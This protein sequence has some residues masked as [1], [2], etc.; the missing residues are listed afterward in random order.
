MGENK[1]YFWFDASPPQTGT[2]VSSD[3]YK[4]ELRQHFTGWHEAVQRLIDVVDPSTMARIEIHDTEPLLS[5][6]DPSGR[7]VIIGDAAHAT[8]PD[9]GQGG[10]QALED[11][12]VLGQLFKKEG[13]HGEAQVVNE[14]LQTVSEG[15]QK[16]RAER[17]AGLVLRARKRAEVTHALNGMD[18]T[19][20]TLPMSGSVFES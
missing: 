12:F 13:L 10:C 5:L 19:I 7:A 9:L 18:E 8:T 16:S 14:K 1:F 4:D 15:Y 3:T 6:T 20:G 11:S 2:S 17:V